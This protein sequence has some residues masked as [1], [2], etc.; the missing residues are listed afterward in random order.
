MILLAIVFTVPQLVIV[1]H[2][3]F[4]VARLL[5]VDAHKLIVIDVFHW[6]HILHHNIWFSTEYDCVYKLLDVFQWK[7]QA[8]T[9][10][11]DH[12]IHI[13]H[14]FNQSNI[15]E[16][17]EHDPIFIF[18]ISLLKKQDENSQLL[19]MNLV[20]SVDSAEKDTQEHETL[21]DEAIVIFANVILLEDMEH[22]H[23]V[24][25]KPLGDV[26]L[27]HDIN[28]GEFIFSI[29]HDATHTVDHEIVEKLDV[30]WHATVHDT[31]EDQNQKLHIQE[32]THEHHIILTATVHAQNIFV[33]A[34]ESVTTDNQF[35][36]IDQDHISHNH[37]QEANCS[38]HH[39]YI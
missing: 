27:L 31:T 23:K 6:S 2:T 4:H 12:R 34:E 8:D 29:F 20:E 39:Q 37:A 25:K 17:N 30:F 28:H 19:H 22:S 3:T 38:V 1:D 16:L 36:D 26:I 5:V 15:Q 33:E 11:Y 7:I 14:N 24:E 21:K 13:N 32:K 35:T 9:I 10:L 18:C